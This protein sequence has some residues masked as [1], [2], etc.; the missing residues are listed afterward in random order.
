MSISS[1]KKDIKTY[2]FDIDGVICNTVNGN[3]HQA[4][5]NEKAIK[6][7]NEIY[8]NGNKVIIF[9]ARFMGRT[10]NDVKKAESLGYNETLTQLKK[11]G[12]KF[13]K[14]YM[15]KP[16]YDIFIDDKAYN[17]NDDWIKKI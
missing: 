6:K 14:L 13:H 4:I 7:I 15:G 5:P 16:S 2:A 17:Y 3:Y 10:N 11:W 9:T 12:V 1:L 8:L